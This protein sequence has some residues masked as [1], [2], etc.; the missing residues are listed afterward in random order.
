MSVIG[1]T[2]TLMIACGCSGPVPHAHVSSAQQRA[3]TRY[4]LAKLYLSDGNPR[5]GCPVDILGA[6][7]VGGR[8]RVYT[9]V[10]CTSASQ[11]CAGGLDFTSGL[12]ADL[13]GTKVVSTEQDDAEGYQGMISEAS[14]YPPSIRSAAINDINSGGPVWLRQAAGVAAGC[15]HGVH[16]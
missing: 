13:V 4:Y 14:I 12:V 1:V 16:S 2:A 7:H 3:I 5:V 11:N 6:A 15:V 9:V 10:H 8:L